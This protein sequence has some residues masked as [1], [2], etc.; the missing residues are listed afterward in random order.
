M[1]GNKEIFQKAMNQGHSAAWDQDWEKAASCYKLALKEIP[2]HPQALSSLGLALFEMQNYPGSLDCY[3]KA[4]Q[5]SP[6]DAIPQEKIA[7]IYERMGKPNEAVSS[8]MQAAE[9]H[10]KARSV[11]KAIDNWQRILT[12]QP[13]NL[14][15]RFRLAAV[16]EKMGRQDDA[17]AEY[18]ATASILQ[19]SG[20]VGRAVKALEIGA[21]G[22]AR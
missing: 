19:R 16:Y 1:A 18:I 14:T 9:L 11:D 8:S 21:K 15:V 10:L 20:E 12:Y 6:D 2:N 5:I 3:L 4:S 13:D 17:T 22:N 7:R